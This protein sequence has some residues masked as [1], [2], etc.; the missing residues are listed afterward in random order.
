M[1]CIGDQPSASLVSVVLNS[2]PT[3]P[4]PRVLYLFV[5]EMKTF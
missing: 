2:H 5:S 1:F 4:T 3:P